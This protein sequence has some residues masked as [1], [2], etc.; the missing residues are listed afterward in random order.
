MIAGLNFYLVTR[1]DNY[2]QWMPEV[3]YNPA[4]SWKIKIHGIL[5]DRDSSISDYSYNRQIFGLGVVYHF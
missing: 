3:S 5:I 2:L 1:Q 4:G